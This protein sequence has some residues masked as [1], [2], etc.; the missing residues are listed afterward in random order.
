MKKLAIF[1]PTRSRSKHLCNTIRRITKAITYSG[2]NDVD[3]IIVDNFSQ[4]D[5]KDVV[6]RWAEK[7]NYIKYYHQLE[8]QASAESS[9]LKG[10]D[11]IDAEY[12]WV[13]GD[14]DFPLIDC[15]TKLFTTI[16][17]TDADFILFSFDRFVKGKT[18]KRSQIFFNCAF[19]K[20]I[21]EYD[22][23]K[24]MFVDFG[25]ISLTSLIPCMC[26]KVGTLDKAAFLKLI[27]TS[28]IY[29][30]SFAILC[31]YYKS[32]VA[33]SGQKLISYRVPEQTEYCL[34]LSQNA[35][36]QNYQ[37]TT[38]LLKLIDTASEI[39]SQKYE[40]IVARDL[41][42]YTELQ[43]IMHI[44]ATRN[45][46]LWCLIL[47]MSVSQILSFSQWEE[48]QLLL[49]NNEIRLFL[50]QTLQ[51]IKELNYSSDLES[52]E[53]TI[54]QIANE[55]KL[56]TQMFC[57]NSLSATEAI[58]IDI[59]NRYFHRD[60]V[61]KISSH[62]PIYGAKN[63]CKITSLEAPS[64][65]K[66][67]LSMLLCMHRGCDHELFFLLDYLRKYNFSQIP[68]VEIIIVIATP[69][70]EVSDI[71]N[72]FKDLK[73]LKIIYYDQ[74]AE[75]RED[76]VANSIKFCQGE[77]VWIME[78]SVIP[79]ISQ[80]YFML[81]KV[82][83]SKEAGFIFN[84]CND[85][86][87]HALAMSNPYGL[88]A[89]S[90]MPFRK[91]EEK[92]TLVNFIKAQGILVATSC[93][94]IIRK[95]LLG[96]FTPY[97]KRSST[98][99][100]MFGLLEFLNKCPVISY[101]IPIALRKNHDLHKILSYNSS[102]G[103]FDHLNYA[104]SISLTREN[105]LFTLQESHH[106][107]KFKFFYKIVES[108]CHQCLCYIIF[109]NKNI[110]T[111]SNVSIKNF[112]HSL[113]KKSSKEELLILDDFWQTYGQFCQYIRDAETDHSMLTLYK[114]RFNRIARNIAPITRPGDK[115]KKSPKQIVVRETNRLVKQLTVLSKKL[116]KS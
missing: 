65:N 51:L 106:N 49:K 107:K 101:D 100:I 67:T 15:I 111:L 25:F 91:L 14:D 115:H 54:R 6:K 98:H 23:G 108:L 66:V 99:S 13:C 109:S 12:V 81:N 85:K 28:Q 76:V 83:N 61:K 95:S 56:L 88:M 90:D 3:L 22:N 70:E 94:Y 52:L 114:K 27:E 53:S 38:G 92:T 89:N 58:T 18:L 57:N 80:F 102:K 9:M 7:F 110:P 68:D 60:L 112:R 63:F 73:N 29:S 86:S 40:K 41:L 34:N 42:H 79:L 47:R 39:I 32:K 64:L 5:T 36:F 113:S 74:P 97:I 104:R 116:K 11:F 30:H 10:L 33:I 46:L 20:E 59:E 87:N 103:L 21:L 55:E 82:R 17:K 62:L 44:N 93:F 31:S 35:I 50:E 45:T 105:L 24:E 96:D 71:C 48:R 75:S 2:R 19:P 4:D 69:Y 37:W 1:I 26:F 8:S 43:P 84:Y 16:S 77:F 78:D 72:S